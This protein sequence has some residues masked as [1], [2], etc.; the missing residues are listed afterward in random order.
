MKRITWMRWMIAVPVVVAAAGCA[1]A[2]GDPGG[3]AGEAGVAPAD[4]T[5]IPSYRA[6]AWPQMPNN[7]VLGL[8]SGLAIDSQDHI[9]VIHRPRT[10]AEAD[11]DRAAPAV[12]EFDTEGNFIQGWGGPDYVASQE[13]DWPVTEHG[14]NV[15]SQGNVWISGSGNGDDQ[16]LKFTRDGQ[17]LLQIG[18][19]RREHGQHRHAERE[20]CG[21]HLC[22][23]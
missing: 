21:R 11:R 22:S 1:G 4:E 15:D 5:G 8:A 18:E 12:L 16:I 13:F 2:V 3:S 20:P 6:V 17:F 14:I 19:C 7:W 23:R 10:A 9:W